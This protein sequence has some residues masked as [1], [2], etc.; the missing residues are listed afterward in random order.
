MYF[1]IFFTHTHNI[2]Y[3]DIYPTTSKNVAYPYC[4]PFFSQHLNSVP[5][6]QLLYGLFKE[7]N[8][9]KPATPFRWICFQGICLPSYQGKSPLI[10][11]IY[12]LHLHD[13]DPLRSPKG[14]LAM[15]PLDV[16]T[17][18]CWPRLTLRTPE[19]MDQPIIDIDDAWGHKMKRAIPG[20]LKG[21]QMDG[22]WC[23]YATGLNT[24]PV[25]VRV[26]IC[27]FFLIGDFR[28]AN[29]NIIGY[30][31]AHVDFVLD[32]LSCLFFH[33]STGLFTIQ[34]SFSVFVGYLTHLIAMCSSLTTY[35]NFV[36]MDSFT[37]MA[38]NIPITSCHKTERCHRSLSVWDVQW[39][40]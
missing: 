35:P 38:R 1:F 18:Q 4:I 17:F 27:L 36:I 5:E 15:Q 20:P 19:S 7:S 12:R 21:Y 8:F 28:T 39:N 3:I 23:H 9:R 32:S 11:Q 24:H 25:R 30:K 22:K 40:Y 29:V 26:Y 16:S 6:V 31:L 13:I 2:V 33:E 10:H 37:Q 34:W 14:N